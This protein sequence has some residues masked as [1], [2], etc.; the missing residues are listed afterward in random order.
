MLSA[1]ICFE[2]IEAKSCMFLA[3]LN[4]KSTVTLL[5]RIEFIISLLL[6][7]SALFQE[8]KNNSNKNSSL[9]GEKIQLLET[10]LCDRKIYRDSM[11]NG[12]GVVELDN[13][14]AKKEIK[15]LVQELI[16]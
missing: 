11:S 6:A 2:T 7:L 16:L 4:I 9:S 13:Q 3:L 1:S 5:D 10:V 15:N 8:D 14:K 12:H